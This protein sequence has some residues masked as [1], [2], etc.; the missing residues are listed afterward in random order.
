MLPKRL[1]AVRRTGLLDTPADEPFDRLARLACQILD[2]P[3]AFVTIVDE[4]RSFWKACIGVNAT[5]P[6]E[7]QNTVQ[8]SFC[9]YV[10]AADDAVII[11]DARLDPMTAANPSIESMGVIAWAGFP[12]RSPDGYVLGTFCVVDTQPRHWQPDQLRTLE[13][14]AQAAS[15]EVA[16]R[17]YADDAQRNAARATLLAATL[18]ESLLPPTLPEV[19]GL[20]L[21]AV[22]VPGGSGVDVL[23]DFYDVV[24]QPRGW[25]VFVGDVSGKGADAAK[26]TALA[27]YTLRASAVRHSSPVPVLAELDRALVHWY[28]QA[29]KSGFATVAYATLTPTA[30][31][32]LVRLCLAGHPPAFVKRAD[33][34]VHPFGLLGTML[35]ALPSLRL[36]IAETTLHPGDSLVLY[37]DGIT[38]ARRGRR[39]LGEDGLA[40]LLTTLDQGNAADLATQLRDAVLAHADS[41]AN[42]DIA[43]LVIQVPA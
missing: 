24:P 35:G 12:V 13:V 34:S 36:S 22:Y 43:I 38:E 29:G 37:T 28:E 6:A 23:G 16:L 19:V 31:G 11:D 10:I 25:A 9:Q 41:P 1:E 5:S 14:L 2:A 42:D 26:T 3:F 27:R 40:R 4:R 18:Q 17:I 32:T 8:E 21:A 7:R 20:D 39:L 30:D 15:G 33:G